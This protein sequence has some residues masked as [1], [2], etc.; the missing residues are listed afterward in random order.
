MSK[1]LCFFNSQS[2]TIE[3]ETSYEAQRAAALY[4]GL[5]RRSWKVSVYLADKVHVAVD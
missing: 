2:I 1:Y 5:G 3:A 4:F